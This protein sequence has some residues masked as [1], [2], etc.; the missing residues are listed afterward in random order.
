MQ[1]QFNDIRHTLDDK[2]QEIRDC[3]ANTDGL[4]FTFASLDR[5]KHV[6]RQVLSSLEVLAAELAG[7]VKGTASGCRR[8]AA[9]LKQNA[10]KSAAERRRRP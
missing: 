2:R 6:Y 5:Q 10:E 1:H 8:S 3:L 4:L 9:T 7:D